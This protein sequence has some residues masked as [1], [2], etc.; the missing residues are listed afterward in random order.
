MA[1]QN[2]LQIAQERVLELLQSGTAQ[3]NIN[4][5][6]FLLLQELSIPNFN[7]FL[8]RMIVRFIMECYH[9]NIERVNRFVCVYHVMTINWPES[10]A[11][12]L[13]AINERLTATVQY[14]FLQSW[15]LYHFIIS[16]LQHGIFVRES[17]Q[18]GKTNETGISE[19]FT[20]RLRTGNY[21]VEPNEQEWLNEVASNLVNE[22]VFFPPNNP[23]LA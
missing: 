1:E 15:N 23:P 12:V 2:A 8:A 3:A 21:Q 13:A 11:L 20:P 22:G 17:L 18:F 4:Q 7:V 5:V 6:K 14:D 9:H 10:G 16:C 19:P